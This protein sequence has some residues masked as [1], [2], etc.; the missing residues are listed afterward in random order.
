MIIIIYSRVS[1]RRDSPIINY[2]I[3]CHPL[4]PYSALPVHKSWRILPA[5]PFINACA[6]LTAENTITSATLEMLVNIPSTSFVP[7]SGHGMK[8]NQ[9]Q[10]KT[11]LILMKQDAYSIVVKQGHSFFNIVQNSSTT[12]REEENQAK[13]QVIFYVDKLTLY[14]LCSFFWYF[15][16]V[17]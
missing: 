11:H 16:K 8:K 6:E 3:F 12:Q 2:S 15:H 7:L 5:S 17:V 10:K 14:F 9:N 1:K 4:Q 13:E